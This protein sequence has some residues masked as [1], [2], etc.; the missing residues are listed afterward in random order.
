M[1]STCLGR[2]RFDAA[3]LMREHPPRF[4][5]AHKRLVY[6]RAM[7][8]GAP[9]GSIAY[10]RW[11]EPSLPTLLSDVAPRVDLR[12]DVFGYEPE[13]DGVVPWY[14]NFAHTILFVAYGGPLLAQDELQVLEH[15]ALGS[16]REVLVPGTDVGLR[17]VTREDGRATPVLITGVERRCAL[18]TDVDL[19][20]GR[21]LGL[22]GNRFARAS[23]DTVLRSLRVLDPPTRSNLVALE[24]PPGG[25]GRYTRDD[26]ARA[27]LTA[28]A[29]FAA[30]R[31]ES[32]A[33]APDAAVVLHTG[34]W[35]TGAYGGDRVLMAMVQLLAARMA[36]IERV[37]F[38]TV[39]AEGVA[40][41]REAIERVDN[42][43]SRTRDVPR[44]VDAL[45]AMGFVWGSSDGN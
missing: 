42:L 34:H 36:G 2:T 22:Y 40:P 35:G 28:H 30:V 31:E 13:A 1:T 9:R 23:A 3:S 32:W 38:H 27:L 4:K 7:A 29:G 44:I 26:I 10:S 12:D 20:A 17:P 8:T 6:E 11:D 14:L 16:L 41:A 24:A 5:L 33:M 25:A 37:V 18:A 39:S 15:P 43:T 21:P 45:D 19:E